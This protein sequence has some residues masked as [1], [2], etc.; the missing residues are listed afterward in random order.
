MKKII[1]LLVLLFVQ[2]SFAQLDYVIKFSAESW[3]VTKDV[4]KIEEAVYFAADNPKAYSTAVYTFQ[5]GKLQ[6]LVYKTTDLVDVYK[7][8]YNT[9][10]NPIKYT[11]TV[12]DNKPRYSSFIYDKK[13]RLIE[14]MPEESSDFLYKYQYDSSGKLSSIE[15]YSNN[16][17]SNKQVITSYKD[18]KNYN[19]IAEMYSSSDGKKISESNRQFVNG[20]EVK[21]KDLLVFGTDVFGSILLMRQKDFLHRTYAFYSRKITYKDGKV[22]GSTDYNPYFTEGINGDI[23]QLPENKNPKSTYKIRLGEDGKFKMENQANQPIPDLSK[24]FISPNKT[25]FIYFDPNNGEVALVEDMKPS[26]DFVTMK[27]Y[28]VPSKRYIV[29]NNDY[30][31]II[32]DN[33][34]QIDTSSMKLA[35]DMGNLVIQE[36]GVPKYFV[37]N[38]DKLTFLK[39]YPLYILAL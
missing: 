8:E 16:K 3:G 17:L 19:F 20:M 10:G 35:Q 15:Q 5:N 32:F 12:N 34:K 27:P 7:F 9:K 22:T 1:Q 23:S 38:L 31:F 30:Q 2:F 37:P 25:D 21:S 14:I 26:E 18:N 4:V 11:S 24:G 28:N 39:F 29:I 6:N 13:G 36:N 33:G